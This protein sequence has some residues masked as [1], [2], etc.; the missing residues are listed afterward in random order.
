MGPRPA[1]A[2]ETA[3]WRLGQVL[4]EQGCLANQLEDPFVQNLVKHQGSL[5][6]AVHNPADVDQ[7]SLL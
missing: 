3:S 6:T 7:I 1:T 4:S 5:Q 2:L